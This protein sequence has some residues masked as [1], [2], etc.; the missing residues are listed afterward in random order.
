MSKILPFFFTLALF[1]WIPQAYAG[2]TPWA[3][4]DQVRARLLSGGGDK[5]ALEIELSQGWHSY[6]RA[7]GD[8]GLAPS[9]NW[10]ASENI[11]GVDIEWPYPKRFDEMGLVTFGYEGN[12]I[13]PLTVHKTAEGAKTKVDLALD[14]MVCADICIPQQLKMFI[15]LEDETQ[16]QLAIIA[17]ASKKTPKD[18]GFVKIETIVAGPDALVITATSAKGFEKA[19]IFA[20]IGD[21]AL[22]AKPEITPDSADSRKAMIRIPKG[23]SVP[24]FN[25]KD[26]YVVL[27]ADRHAAHKSAKF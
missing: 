16:T 7:P 9:F 17:A 12:V 4:A 1:V 3:N 24:D 26:I 20:I 13:F 18:E 11:S 19:D 25:G 5:A 15:D 27:V 23:E 2:E 10:S 8:A 22:V 21:I 6:W 14:I